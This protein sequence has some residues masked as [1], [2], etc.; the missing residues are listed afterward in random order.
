MYVRELTVRFRQ[1]RI[2][3]RTAPSRICEP[4]DAVVLLV[5]VLGREVVE[6]CGVLCLSA[7]N[8][9][10]AYHELSRGTLDMS[11][12]HPRDLFRSALL[13]HASTVV[14]AH[15]HPSGDPRPSVED[16]ALT[17]RL[18]AAGALIGVT[19]ADHLI[20][21]LNGQYYSFKEAGVL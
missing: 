2:A 14:V 15:N 13:A 20:V 3:G 17:K 11:I 9:L 19:L 8:D 10:L 21:A 12:V 1:R 4:R 16:V 5:P 6:V 7:R 18:K